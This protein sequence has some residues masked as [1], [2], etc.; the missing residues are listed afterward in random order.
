MSEYEE[1]L[2]EEGA[3]VHG[4]C[5]ELG[6]APTAEQLEAGREHMLDSLYDYIPDD[7]YEGAY[8]PHGMNFAIQAFRNRRRNQELRAQHAASIEPNAEG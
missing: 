4:I 7:L 8:I 6:C 2:V 3:S 1:R 5:G